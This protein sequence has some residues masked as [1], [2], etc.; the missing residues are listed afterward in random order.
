MNH[1][2]CFLIEVS[3]YTREAGVRGLER[4]L[5]ALCRAA[6]VHIANAKIKRKSSID[7]NGNDDISTRF[8]YLPK[9][10]D[11]NGIK[12][13]KTINIDDTWTTKFLCSYKHLLYVNQKYF[14]V[15]I[16]FTFL[17]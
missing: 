6:A 12:E 11:D 16:D 3:K 13:V 15:L 5:G 9:Q 10:D 14:C 1:F 2:S 7:S 17:F 8:K 4:K